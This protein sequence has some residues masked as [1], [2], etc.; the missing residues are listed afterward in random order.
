[1]PSVLTEAVLERLDEGWA[2][3]EV[4]GFIDGLRLDEEH[5]AALW[6]LAWLDWRPVRSPPSHDS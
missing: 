3:D 1:M 4:E 5:A 2:L 6:L